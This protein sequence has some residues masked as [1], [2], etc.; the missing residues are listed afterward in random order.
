MAFVGVTHPKTHELFSEALCFGVA[1]GI[2]AGYSFCPSVVR[3]GMGTGLHIVGRYKAMATDSSWYQEF[4]DR[5]EL[6]SHITETSAKKKALQNLIDE[7][8]QGHPTIVWCSRPK[9]PFILNS[10]DACDGFMG[11]FLVSGVDEGNNVALVNDRAPTKWTL[12]LEQLAEAR[13]GV[14]SHKNRTFTLHSTGDVSLKQLQSAV[15]LG[16]RACAESMLRGR[17]GTFTLAGLDKWVKLIDNDKNKDG[18]LKL[19]RD[20]LMYRALRD[21]YVSIETLSDVGGLHRALYHDFLVEAADI[22]EN[23]TLEELAGGY[24]VLHDRW[25]ELANCALPDD[26]K[27]FKAAKELITKRAKVYAEKGAKGEKTLGSTTN[28]LEKVEA[29][30][31]N[32]FPL[33]EDHIRD[34]LTDLKEQITFIRNEEAEHAEGL[35]AAVA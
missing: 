28:K 18:W 11:Q 14:C 8:E 13:A 22:L 21:V 24:Q 19:Y 5:L 32:E 29:E 15:T 2:G 35:L 3:H 4:C 26:I 23:P 16:I 31:Q 17:I 10:H 33:T 34:I 25:K 1:G 7:L 6:D 12:S 27:P 30:I 9:I 20:G